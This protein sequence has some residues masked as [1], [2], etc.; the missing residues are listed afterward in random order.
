M[1]EIDTPSTRFAVE[2]PRSLREKS[3]ACTATPGAFCRSLG[4]G[5]SF[6]PLRGCQ[7]PVLHQEQGNV[8]T[9]G[10]QVA[11]Q[12]VDVQGVS[13]FEGVTGL[14]KHVLGHRSAPYIAGPG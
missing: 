3:S 1:L 6:T 5:L 11:G 14:D 10:R 8:V 2:M 12:I 4:S 13:I 9:L 7:D